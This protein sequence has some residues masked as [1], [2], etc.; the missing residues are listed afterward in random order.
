MSDPLQDWQP[1]G[2]DNTTPST[3]RMY[4]Y[5][6]GGKDNY[7]VDREAADKVV[8]EHPQ[9]RQLA[10]NN[11]AFLVRAVRSI[12]Q[13]GIAQFVD[14]GTG[15][16]TSPSVHEV[17]REVH[18]GAR[19][20]YVDNDPVVLAHNRALLNPDD[21]VTTIDGDMRDP[22]GILGNR[23]LQHLIDFDHPVGVLFVSVF[24]FVPG[25][26]P[27]RIV[28]RFRDAMA[29][30]SYLAASVGTSEGLSE[31]D[32]ARISGGYSSAAV[33]TIA[34]PREQI[35]ELFAGSDL[36]EPGLVD[37]SQWRAAEPQTHVKILAG[38]GRKR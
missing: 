27:Q 32:I 3:A 18:P 11:R 31:E 35:E 6:L 15:I 30:G 7:P 10:R 29:P 34:R 38:V 8:A 20:V 17:A 13:D 37:V 4:D 1:R 2:V 25:D 28:S 5:Y 9:Q 23:E 24:H 22:E 16:P 36:L 26:E 19:V 33:S 21:G 12:A 14:V